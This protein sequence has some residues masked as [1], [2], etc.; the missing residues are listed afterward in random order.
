MPDIRGRF[1]TFSASPDFDFEIRT[2]LGYS[3]EG[4]CD[5]GEVLAAVSTVDGGDHHGWFAAWRAL[6]E[7][8]A[9]A[10]A[11]SAAA[12]HR[13]SAAEGNLR[14][15]AYLG[16]A[17]N[18]I[19]ALA[20]HSQLASTF[21]RQ[22]AAWDAFTALVGEAVERVEVPYELTSLPGYFFRPRQSVANGATLVAVNGSDG[23]LAGMWASCA[24]AALKR[25]YSVLLFDGPGQQSQLFTRG[26]PFRPD[27][28]NVLTPVYDYV[29]RLH[30]VDPSRIA[31]FGLSQGGYWV[32]RALAYEHRYAAAI[33]DPG[34]V[35][36]A[37]SWTAHLPESLLALLDAGE[38]EK[39]DKTMESALAGSV[40]DRRTWE[41]RA[42]PYGTEGYAATIAAVRNYSLT[43]VAGRITTPLLITDPEGEQFWPGQ[44]RQLAGLAPSVSTVVAFTAAEGAAGH[45]EPLARP[46]VAQRMFDWLD[47]QLAR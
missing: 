34:V 10:A 29:S 4:A 24:S 45:C 31:V 21:T 32:P 46:L 40:G 5:P 43:D 8:T 17:V 12:G 9:V 26:V 28:E 2:I 41:F 38:N 14:A 1:P 47:A 37:T 19:S 30:G 13:V 7:Q 25:G 3:A 20:D 35:D 23:S 33:A 39:F 18:A 16:V 44:S 36:V 11:V 15:S 27:W 6:G 22:Q 42:R